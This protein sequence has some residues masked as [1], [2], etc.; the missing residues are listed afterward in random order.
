[1]TYKC[2]QHKGST[3]QKPIKPDPKPET[4]PPMPVHQPKPETPG[5][6]QQPEPTS[7]PMPVHQPKPTP[8]PN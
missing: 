1:M 6:P 8:K 7:P 3:M 2:T 4:S 5:T